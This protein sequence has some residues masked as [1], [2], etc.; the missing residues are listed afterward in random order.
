MV[1]KSQKNQSRH[2]SAEMGGLEQI[3]NDHISEMT[4][5]KGL[6]LCVCLLWPQYI[7]MMKFHQNLW[8]GHL[9]TFLE[10]G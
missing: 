4:W 9:G 10:I 8:G 2:A 3:S 5:S 1:S 6:I 7:I